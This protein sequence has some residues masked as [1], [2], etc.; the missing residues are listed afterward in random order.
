MLLTKSSMYTL[1][2]SFDDVN[3]KTCHYA[4]TY[5]EF[6]HNLNMVQHVHCDVNTFS[7]YFTSSKFEMFC[8]EEKWYEISF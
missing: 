1:H 3:K 5:I 6:F 2:S 8:E 7:I 4:F